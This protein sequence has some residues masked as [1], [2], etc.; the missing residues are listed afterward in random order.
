MRKRSRAWVVRPSS[1][2]AWSSSSA[3]SRSRTRT[4]SPSNR[5]TS[6]SGCAVARSA[7]AL[8]ITSAIRRSPFRL[9]AAGESATLG[10]TP[11][12]SSLTAR[13]STLSS[14]SVGSTWE[15]YSM[16]V[17]FGPTTRTRRRR[18]RCEKRRN[19]ARWSPTAVLPVPGPPWMTSGGSGSRVMSRYWSAWIVATMSRMYGSRLRSSSS[20]RKSPPATDPDPS[21]VSSLM[22][23]RRRPSVR[24]RRRR[25]TLCGFAG[26]AT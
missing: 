18:S 23:S 24:N 5:A 4:Y 14:P 26:V 25:V 21:R 20:R 3:T 2:R 13:C 10:E 6:S 8:A 7:A 12:A 17:G 9:S 11:S 22:S 1:S 19:E 15:T 16:N